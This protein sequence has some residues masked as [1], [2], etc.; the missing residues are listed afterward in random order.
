MLTTT[1]NLNK[2]FVNNNFMLD[3]NSNLNNPWFVYEIGET[4][5]NNNGEDYIIIAMDKE[6]DKMILAKK[7]KLGDKNVTYFI[8]AKGIGMHHW[9]FGHY[10]MENF[11]AACEW[12]NK[13]DEDNAVTVEQLV[14]L[15]ADKDFATFA[16]WDKNTLTGLS[17]FGIHIPKELKECKVS[18]FIVYDN[19][20]KE[21]EA[22]LVYGIIAIQIDAEANGVDIMDLAYLYSSSRIMNHGYCF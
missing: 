18:K 4:Y 6:K 21:E 3:K 9:A 20:D 1:N 12:F 14:N 5:H 17:F 2:T 19:W 11:E 13:D 10:F 7:S 15:Y 22:D 8:G 16:I